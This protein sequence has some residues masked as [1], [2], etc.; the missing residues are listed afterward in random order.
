LAQGLNKKILC[1]LDECG[2]AGDGP[3]YF[4]AVLVS[5][6]NASRIDKIFSDLLDADANEIHASTLQDEYSQALLEKLRKSIPSNSVVLLNHRP[7][8]HQDGSPPIVYAQALI[9]TVKV[10][11]KRFRDDILKRSAI[12][13]VELII[14]INDHNSDATFDSEIEKARQHGLFKG[15]RHVAK[16]DSAASRMLQVADLVAYSRRWIMTKK[17]NAAAIRQ[18][19]GI[20]IL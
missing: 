19:F 20:E 8:T 16:V 11:M 14:D 13:N 6:R 3:C 9:E 7:T 2:T 4:G 18:R 17:I 5:A 15:V 12:G 10:G 1:F